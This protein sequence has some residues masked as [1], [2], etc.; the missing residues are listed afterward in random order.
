MKRAVVILRFGITNASV[1]DVEAIKRLTYGKMNAMGC[2][3]PIGMVSLI[4]TD[5]ELSEIKQVF[6]D[7]EGDTGDFLPVMIFNWGDPNVEFDL[8]TSEIE[9]MFSLIPEFCRDQMEVVTL[10][11]DDILDKISRT[12]VESLEQEE[13][14]LL[15]SFS[16]GG[17]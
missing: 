13:L 3:H 14:A 16:R 9:N 15:K 17:K 12:G 1:G 7:V 10:T 4:Y 6:N 8:K 2:P 5:M 11:L